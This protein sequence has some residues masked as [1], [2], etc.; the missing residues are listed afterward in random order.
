MAPGARNDKRAEVTARSCVRCASASVR[1]A[2]SGPHG[3]SRRETN[4]STTVPARLT[5]SFSGAVS[6]RARVWCRGVATVGLSAKTNRPPPAVY[7]RHVCFGSSSCWTP[8]SNGRSRRVSSKARDV[9]P[10]VFSS[11]VVVA[12]ERSRT[13]RAD[14]ISRVRTASKRGFGSHSTRHAIVVHDRS[15]LASWPR[16]GRKAPL[17]RRCRRH[18][19]KEDGIAPVLR[20]FGCPRPPARSGA[21]SLHCGHVFKVHELVSHIRVAS[22]DLGRTR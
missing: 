20:A 18:K 9:R 13:L 14:M 7:S 5:R 1:R 3:S 6:A 12:R 21:S 8:S 4:R 19:R 17:T 10:P 2:S 22:D 15:R 11:A 16:G